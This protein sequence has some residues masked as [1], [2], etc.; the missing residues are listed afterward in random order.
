MLAMIA[1]ARPAVLVKIILSSSTIA[2]QVAISSHG[3]LWRLIAVVAA[4]VRLISSST[5]RHIRIL[6]RVAVLG[7]CH[8]MNGCTSAGLQPLLFAMLR[9]AVGSVIRTRL[10]CLGRVL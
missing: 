2:L 8:M 10:E 4:I 5:A 1:A 3:V 6:R 9:V 7:V